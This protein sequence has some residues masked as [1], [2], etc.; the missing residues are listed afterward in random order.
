MITQ[1]K[2]IVFIIA[3]K[4][5]RGYPSYLSHYIDNIINFYGD[6]S[7]IL[8]VDNNSNYPQE[9]F[10]TIPKINNLV[11]LTNDIECKFELGA[12][13]VGM[14]YIFEEE[15]QDECEYFVCTQ[16]NFIIKNKVDFDNLLKLNI[17]ACP[18][19]SYFPD[20]ECKNICDTVLNS[21]GRNDNLDKI[22]FCWCSSFIV[23]GTK[24][25]TIYDMIKQ[26]VIKV[27]W[28]SCASER[29]LARLLWELNDFKNNDIDG[30]IRTLKDRHY[31]CW[32]V[33]PMAPSSSFF[34]KKVQQKTE[35]TADKW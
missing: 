30:D 2:K 14:R 35:N 18:I 25:Q 24:L 29:Y 21:L 9:I 12:Y 11:F 23:H 13:Q 8:V 6:R 34:V 32:S 16:D 31:D 17:F 5:F 33:D 1:E 20:G 19:N 28:E 7:L 15:L 27:R 3:H 26:I 10:D 22:T 4:Y